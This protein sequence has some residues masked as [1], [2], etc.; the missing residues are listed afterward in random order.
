[1]GFEPAVFMAVLLQWGV[2]AIPSRIANRNVGAML[3][4]ARGAMVANL[5]CALWGCI[6]SFIEPFLPHA[7]EPVHWN[8]ISIAIFCDRLSLTMYLLVSFVGL[9]VLL[10]SGRYLQ[11]EKRQGRFVRWLSFTLAAVCTMVL[12][13]NLMVFF[14]AWVLTSFGLHQLLTHY[15][16]RPNAQRVAFKKFVISRFGDAFLIGA[17]ALIYRVCGTLDY[18]ELFRMIDVS[19]AELSQRPELTWAAILLVLGGLTKS[20][21]F[22][23]HTWL[24]DTMETPTPVSALMHAG[25]IN[26]GGYLLIRVSPLLEMAPVAM[27]ILVIL[28]GLT[29]VIGAAIMLTQTNVKRSL[30]YS[31]IAQMGMM[32]LQCGLGAFSAAFLHIIAHSLYKSYAFLSAGTLRSPA[33]SPQAATKQTNS[34]VGYAA[35]ILLCSLVGMVIP[36]SVCVYLNWFSIAKLPL[37]MVFALAVQTL[38]L[39][40][41]QAYQSPIR[42]AALAVGMGSIYFGVTLMAQWYLRDSVPHSTDGM[43]VWQWFNLAYVA[44]TFFALWGIQVLVEQA[45]K[46]PFTRRLY[47]HMVNELYLDLIAHRF[48]A[49]FKAKQNYLGPALIS[50][51]ESNV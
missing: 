24:P 41:W 42:T 32:M 22:P 34:G 11:G 2:A 15:A 23:F 38:V 44:T 7:F 49:L 3:T 35:S 33:I 12:A 45:P 39:R 47:A 40:V 14:V 17:I 13:A 46:H 48:V 50:G 29:A 21:Q 5:V 31:T 16:D 4:V 6:M 30:A 10:Y 26:A 19:A 28:G 37:V 51:K 25:V 8:G 20:A 18:A 36:F 9:A 1:M 43:T 27:T